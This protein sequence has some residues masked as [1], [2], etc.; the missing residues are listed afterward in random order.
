M[1]KIFPYSY[2]SL[3]SFETCPRKYYEE[4][5]LKS[6]VRTE[7]AA[8]AAGTAL[9]LQAENYANDSKPFEHKY[10]IQIMKVVD[11]LKSNTDVIMIPEA[12][13][14]VTKDLKPT[15]FWAE[16]CYSRGKIDIL[17]LGKEEATIVDWKTGKSDVFSTQLKH[18]A[19]LVM[20]NNP[21]I[22]RVYTKY[23]WLKEGYATESTI[24]RVFL[25]ENW[26][27]FEGRASKL[28]KAFTTNV[29]PEKKSGLCKNYCDVHTCSHN[30]QYKN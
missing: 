17:A 20:A 15:T 21:N 11:K 30:G 14:A 29:W 8:A 5:I 12:E 22:Q 27:K 6:T 3:S 23:E 9:H 10:A 16:D 25:E 7:N 1:A 18:N 26:K 28:E 19:V 13:V 24:H 2:S 4:R